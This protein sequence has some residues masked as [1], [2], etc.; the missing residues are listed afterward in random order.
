MKDFS[1]KPHALI[2]EVSD[3]FT[4]RS[5]GS[6]N[7][8]YSTQKIDVKKE[9]RRKKEEGRGKKEEGRRKRE[10]GRGNRK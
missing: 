1:F 5:S 3:I 4:F 8:Y 6:Q 10:K 2:A 7:Y 9:W